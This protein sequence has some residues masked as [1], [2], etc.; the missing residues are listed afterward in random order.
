M[1]HTLLHFKQAWYTI[2]D[3][4]TLLFYY[5]FGMFKALISKIMPAVFVAALG[6]AAFGFAAQ[7]QINE[8]LNQPTFEDIGRNSYNTE[9]GDSGD[10]NDLTSIVVT[11]INFLL[12]LLGI[13]FL[14]IIIYAGFLWMT[15]GGNDDQVGKAKGLIKNAIIGV[16]I[17]VAAYAITNFVLGAIIEALTGA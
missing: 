8:A 12:S 6:I 13:I 5:A 2:S 9:P 11:I 3:F 10:F 17:I 1:Y 7:A 14:I 16:V 15:A 4:S